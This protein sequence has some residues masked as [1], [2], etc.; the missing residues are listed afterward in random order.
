LLLWYFPLSLVA[1]L[2]G[3]RAFLATKLH[4]NTWHFAFILSWLLIPLCG[5]FVVSMLF[6]PMLQ[7]RYLIICLPALVLLPSIV[8]PHLNRKWVAVLGGVMVVLLGKS[9]FLQYTEQ[10]K[11]DWRD[12]VQFVLA[13]AQPQDAVVFYAYFVREPFEYYLRRFGDPLKRLTPY[14]IA[15]AHQIEKTIFGLEAPNLTLLNAL[16]KKHPR[17]WLVLSHD[18]SKHV[19]RYI[20]REM[21]QQTLEA[22]Y[23]MEM[24]RQFTGVR[25]VRYRR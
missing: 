16:A 2:Q 19:R 18:E 3:I 5:T 15:L 7:P 20:G 8:V 11:E 12:A 1:S 4:G 6:V 10:T 24:E 14:D 13:E 9:L 21:I 22:Q 23:D 17:V 25:I